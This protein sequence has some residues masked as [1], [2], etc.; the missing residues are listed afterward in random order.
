VKLILLIDDDELIRTTFG[1]VLREHGYRVIESDSGVAGLEMARQQVPDLILTDINM[2]G[3]NGHALL[4]HI[5]AD[6]ELSSK[7]IVLMTGRPDL[8]TPRKGMEDGADDFLVKP[9]RREAL[10]SCVDARLKRADLHWRVKDQALSRYNSS[11]ASVLPHEFFTPL[12]GIL[13][14]T[15]ILSTD[16]S[17]LSQEEIHEFHQDIHRSA[18]RLH[19]TLRNYLLLLELPSDSKAHQ[20]QNA[21]QSPEDVK[22]CLQDTIDLVANRFGR[23]HDATLQCGTCSLLLS[24]SDL[25]LVVEETLDNAFKFSRPGTPVTIEL[26]TN[27]LLTVSDSGRGMTEKEIE[28]IGAFR[29]FDRKKSEQQGLGLGLDLVQKL[30]ERNNARFSL[31]SQPGQGVRVQVRFQTQ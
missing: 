3:G 17:G 25:A 2:P 10:L 18:Q 12:A 21:A 15:E 30:A 28:Q 6:P 24:P 8:V 22:K 20:Q 13:G 1:L 29:Q 26:E 31:E 7:Q 9:V 4:H 16:S 19:R 11:M 23:Q 14:L 27:G 5:R